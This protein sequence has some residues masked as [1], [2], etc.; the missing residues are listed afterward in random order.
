MRL[1]LVLR[2]GTRSFEGTATTPSAQ[3]EMRVE[4]D[5]A[6]EVAVETTAPSEIAD[7][8]RR[9]VRIAARDSQKE[10]LALPRMI[11]RWRADKP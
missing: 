3:W 9:V 6:G 5:D 2:H 4:V 10:G 7:Y 11:Q 1:R 8:A